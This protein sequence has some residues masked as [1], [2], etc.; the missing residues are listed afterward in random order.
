MTSFK[1]SLLLC[2][3]ALLLPAAAFA[4][5]VHLADRHTARGAACDKCH[6][7]GTTK[8]PT[9]KECFACH[10]DYKKLADRAAELDIN[11]HDSH[12]GELECAECHQGHQ[13]PKLVCDQCH[14]F[15]GMKVP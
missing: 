5:D 15:R 13:Q 1:T 10:G 12:M 4:A 7:A 3:A 14:E 11:P 6:V 9:A 8:A 2:A